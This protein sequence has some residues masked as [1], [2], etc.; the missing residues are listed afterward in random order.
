MLWVLS[1][2]PNR[3]WLTA[4]KKEAMQQPPTHGHI[5]ADLSQCRCIIDAI[6][7]HGNSSAASLQPRHQ[8]R[9]AR[10]LDAAVRIRGI[11]AQCRCHL[12]YSRLTVA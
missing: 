7:D 6:A 2:P 1:L 11:D 12:P 5:S 8:V 3:A 4:H 10:R 9:F